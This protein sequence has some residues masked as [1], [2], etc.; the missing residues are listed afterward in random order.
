MQLPKRKPGKFNYFQQDPII[1][2]TKYKELQ[3]DLARLK[4]KQPKA[5]QEVS[6]LAEMGDFSENVEYQLAKGRL[7][8]INNAIMKIEHQLDHAEVIQPQSNTHV[9]HIG[10]TVTIEN[11]NGK[12][13]YQILGSSEAHPDKGSISYTSPIGAALMN[14]KLKDIA[15]VHIGERK[16]TYTIVDIQ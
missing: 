16:I 3:K 11:E 15:E 9:V 7:R 13:T 5:A 4:K 6:R 14:K 10:S 12:K 8:G 2:D 1:T